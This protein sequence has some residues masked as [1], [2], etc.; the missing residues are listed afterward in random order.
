MPA[1]ES[2]RVYR[3]LLIEDDASFARVLQDALAASGGGHW[4]VE[5]AV[6]LG[7]GVTRP[8]EP[9]LFSRTLHHVL[10]RKRTTDT[11]LRLEKAV[12]TMQLGVTITDVNGHI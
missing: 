1:V 6:D 5:T 10:E 12:G 3:V 11:L 2:G 9:E 7:A 8:I 4:H